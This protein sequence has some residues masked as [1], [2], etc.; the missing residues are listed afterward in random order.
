MEAY[1]ERIISRTQA[2]LDEQLRRIPYSR[3]VEF[4]YEGFCE[5]PEATLRWIASRISGVR[6]KE[7]LIQKDLRP[8]AVSATVTL[9]TLEKERLLSR[10]QA[11]Y[12]ATETTR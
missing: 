5:A 9:S 4:T 2:E 1:Q 6:L 11:T 10:L 8:F 7:D 3:I 12:Q